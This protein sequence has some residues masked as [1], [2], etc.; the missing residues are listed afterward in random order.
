MQTALNHLRDHLC[1]QHTT[2]HSCA[3]GVCAMLSVPI[4]KL[5]GCQ[6]HSAS[7]LI[8]RNYLVLL[9]AT[10]SQVS[11]A[12][13]SE[14]AS[15]VYRIRCVASSKHQSLM[16]TAR[17]EDLHP[18]NSHH[19]FFHHNQTGSNLLGIDSQTQDLSRKPFSHGL[20]ST[21]KTAEF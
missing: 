14:R 9:I 7:V 2:P 4:R 13:W 1:R 8:F 12:S 5:L 15:R 19:S 16:A 6:I 11:H 20:L 18:V 17:A 10:V 21:S 3:H